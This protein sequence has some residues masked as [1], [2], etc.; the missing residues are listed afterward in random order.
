[1]LVSIIMPS[2]NQAQ[3]LRTALDSVLQQSWRQ[4]E[5]IVM[6]GGSKDETQDILKDYQQR[7]ARLRWWSEPDEGPSDALNK[8]L[9]QCRGTLIGWLNSDDCYTQGAVERAAVAMQQHPEW[10]MCYGAGE[11]IDEQGCYLEDYPTKPGLQEI[12]HKIPD[13]AEFQKGCFICQPSVFFKAVMPRLLGPLDRSLS[14]SF[15][16]DYWLRAFNEFPA[17][18]GFVPAVQAQSR[19][20]DGCIT[21]NQRRKVALEGMKVLAK[22]QGCAEGHWVL[23]YIEEQQRQGVGRKKLENDI[24]NLLDEVQLFMQPL[25]WQVLVDSTG[26]RLATLANE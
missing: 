13:P 9:G 10:I 25:Q 22:H 23:T 16:F 6:D 8:A 5:L 26:R 2:F 20:H 24:Q 12:P 21:Q 7:D 4:L 14:A 19:L 15:D 11:H 17:R 3:F 18:I 1:M